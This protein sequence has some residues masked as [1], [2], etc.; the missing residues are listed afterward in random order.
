MCLTDLL[1]TCAAVVETPL[2]ADAG[3]DSESLVPVLLDRQPEDRPI[4]EAVVH[5]SANGLFAIRQGEWKLVEGL[6][7]GGFSA[8]QTEKPRPDGPRGQLYNLAVDPGEKDNQY[9]R[10]PE[11]VARL[12]KLLDQYRTQGHSAIR[13]RKP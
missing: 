9:L 3:E 1:A 10:H 6:A 12:G 7:S 2:P 5:H 4:H 13:L 11:I 8:P